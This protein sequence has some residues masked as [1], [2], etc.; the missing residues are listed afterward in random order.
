MAASYSY[1][2]SRLAENGK[3]YMRYVIGD[4]N[5]EN[6]GQSAYVSDEAI[7]AMLD[8]F[9]TF[10]MAEIALLKHLLRRFS[11]EVN[12]QVGAL[13]L[14]L[15]DRVEHWRQLLKELQA[16]S[17]SPQA[18]LTAGKD[19]RSRPPLFVVGQFDNRQCWRGRRHVP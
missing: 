5:V 7:Q 3:D 19:G 11:Y 6:G 1:D 17:S 4:V 18:A 9:P 2:E 15:K 12:T 13:R 14:D 8:R 16:E 10:R